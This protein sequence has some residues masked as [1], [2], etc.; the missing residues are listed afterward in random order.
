MVLR[1]YNPSPDLEPYI[2]DYVVM[3]NLGSGFQLPRDKFVPFFGGGMVFHFQDPTRMQR[4]LFDEA[5]PDHLLFGPQHRYSYMTPGSRFDILIVKFKLTGIYHCFGIPPEVLL[6]VNYVDLKLIFG[7]VMDD[8]YQ[9]MAQVKILE[10]RITLLEA[11]IRHQLSL[12]KRVEV[13]GLVDYAVR[14]IIAA[15]GCGKMAAIFEDA[16]VDDRT[17]RRNFQLK[18]GISP[19]LF[20][21]V[22]RIN[23]VLHDMDNMPHVE[24][25]DIIHNY[26]YFDQA[27]FINDFKDIV[28]ETP[29]S[30]IHKDKTSLKIISAMK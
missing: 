4:D 12:R 11:F 24:I 5:M 10:E 30:Y 13:N 19:K 17:F 7:Q 18:V 9:K 15:R 16:G 21:R 25:G 22:V 27:H 6:C 28:G 2:Y 26:S 29:S 3:H 14:R 23:G 8:L 20:A 1:F